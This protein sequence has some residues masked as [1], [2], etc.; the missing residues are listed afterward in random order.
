MSG[1]IFMT[2]GTGLLGRYLIR[3]LL[4]HGKRLALLVRGSKKESPQQRIESILQIWEQDLGRHL[5]RPV[6]I[7]GDL[8]QDGL[9]IDRNTIAWMQSHCSECIHGAAS[10]E[11]HADGT[12]EPWTT[13]FDGTRNMLSL[14]KIAGIRDLHYVSTAYVCGLRDGTVLESELDC[15]Q[16]FRNDYEHSKFRAEA[17]VRDASHI[18]RLTVYRPAVI[19]GDSRTG[20][21]NTYHGIYLY[22]RLMALIIPRLPERPDGSRIAH[23]R[24]PMTGDEQRNV[25]PIDWVSRVISHIFLHPQAHG[26]TYHLVPDKCVTPRDVIDAGANYYRARGVEYV[27]HQEIDPATYN[28]LEAEVL[29]GFAI[30][31]NY[32]NTDPKFDR[33]NLRRFAGHIPCPTIDEAMLHTYLRFGEWDRWGKRRSAPPAYDAVAWDFFNA[34][35]KWKSGSEPPSRSLMGID[36]HGPGGGQWTVHQDADGSVFCIPGLN[37][38]SD[39]LLKLQASEIGRMVSAGHNGD[40]SHALAKLCNSLSSPSVRSA[41]IARNAS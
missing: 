29:P 4:L 13:N 10:L 27:G 41:S 21:T 40:A 36:L 37:G 9:G 26:R 17:M 38:N 12:G 20:Y 22:L 7:E 5:P 25:I 39:A 28:S 32:S 3:D 1:Y 35:A 8:R 15:G 16:T 23:L 6:L 2:G 34:R 24:L 18:D 14:C 11:F 19:A 33:T 30:Y 31:N